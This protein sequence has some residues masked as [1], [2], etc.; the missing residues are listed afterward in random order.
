MTIGYDVPWRKVHELLVEAAVATDGI[1]ISREPFVLQ[2]S[3][4]DWYV[5]YQLNAY[6][7]VPERMAGI[8]SELHG[9]IQDKFN[10][11]GIEIMSPRYSAVRDGNASTIP[12]KGK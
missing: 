4:D 11:A 9:N 8:Y 5:S 10:E 12:E 7:D 1:N 6:T 2:T 3:L